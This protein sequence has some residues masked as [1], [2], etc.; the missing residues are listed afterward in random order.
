MRLASCWQY[1]YNLFIFNRVLLITILDGLGKQ[2]SFGFHGVLLTIWSLIPVGTDKCHQE[3]FARQ[4]DQIRCNSNRLK[5]G[6]NIQFLHRECGVSALPFG[7]WFWRG[8]QHLL[9]WTDHRA[10][11]KL[12]SL[13]VTHRQT[14]CTRSPRSHH[15]IEGL[16]SGLSSPTEHLFPKDALSTEP[17]LSTEAQNGVKTINMNPVLATIIV[18]FIINIIHEMQKLNNLL[19][20][21]YPL[22]NYPLICQFLYNIPF[23]QFYFLD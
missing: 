6:V 13:Q 15:K 20:W 14:W 1:S 21:S 12:F 23:S 9:Q 3:L 4:N 17:M 22:L 8:W 18:P 10:N 7:R 2:F 11:G 16:S 5:L 19:I